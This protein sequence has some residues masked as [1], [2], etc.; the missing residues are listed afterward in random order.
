MR[1]T[2]RR[3]RLTPRRR[4]ATSQSGLDHKETIAVTLEHDGVTGLGEI[5]P[6]PIYGQSLESAEAALPRIADGLGDDPLAIEPVIQRLLRD[7]GDQRATIAAIDSALHDWAARRFNVPLWRWLGLERPRV[8]TMYTISV[9]T[10]AE[11]AEA[12]DEAIAAGFSALK[13]KVGGEHDEAALEAIRAR[14]DGPLL[15]DANQAWSPVEAGKRVEALRRFR[16]WLIEQPV[17]KA[18]WRALGELAALR[19]APIIADE[20]CETPADVAKLAGVVDGVN[21]KLA[22]CGGVREAMRCIAVARACGLRVMLG[23]FLSSGLAVAPALH[24]A[25]L[26]DVI[27]LDGHLLLREDPFPGLE[28][29]GELV[30]A[31]DTPGLGVAASDN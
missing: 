24:I 10:P 22:K 15:L 16:P 9:A 12:V 29:A 6:S 14:F 5:T 3:M 21:I 18:D 26:A 27:D 23:C 30:S 11:V 7:F 19:V 28:S 13:I 4:F 31:P 25:S 2:W 1:L 8:R 17:P 20:S